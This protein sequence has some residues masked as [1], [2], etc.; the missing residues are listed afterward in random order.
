MSK[1]D[2]MKIHDKIRKIKYFDVPKFHSIIV[3]S[4]KELD[5]IPIDYPGNVY[6]LF[7]TKENPAIVR[8]RRNHKHLEING[9]TDEKFY[10]ISYNSSVMIFNGHV[11]L[12]ENSVADVQGDVGEDD[13][14]VYDTSKVVALEYGILN[15]YDNAKCQGG[16]KTIINLFSDNCQIIG[17][18]CFDT[19]IYYGK[20]NI[21]RSDN[22]LLDIE[23]PEVYK[24]IKYIKKAI[25][26]KTII[27]EKNN[28]IETAVKIYRSIRQ[29]SFELNLLSQVYYLKFN[30]DYTKTDSGMKTTN[31]IQ[32][33]K[34]SLNV[35]LNNMDIE[36]KEIYQE[37]VIQF[38]IEFNSK[39][40]SIFQHINHITQ[41]SRYNIDEEI[42]WIE[43]YISIFNV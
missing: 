28:Q 14:H 2:D 15:L 12:H 37:R 6:I 41:E 31:D 17:N 38:D 35:I 33:M 40:S 39:T 32:L 7:G 29:K 18:T 23:I 34:D 4:Q 42:L 5:A 26:Y 8:N 27:N 30:T 36:S 16:F 22:E 25:Q 13:V 19:Y 3:E 1:N 21:G 20:E 10:V 9:I 11:E 24:S 43:K